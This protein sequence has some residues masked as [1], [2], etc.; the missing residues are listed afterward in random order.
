MQEMVEM[1]KMQSQQ[2]DTPQAVAFKIQ[3]AGD[4]EDKQVV[5]SAGP[6]HFGHELRGTDQVSLF[7]RHLI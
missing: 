4:F 1:A 6:A 3:S 2:P 5:M 7:S